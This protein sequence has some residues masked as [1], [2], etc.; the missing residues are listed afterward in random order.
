MTGVSCNSKSTEEGSEIVV[1]PSIVAIKQFSFKS[2]D[3]I[4]DNLDS[5]FF[6]IDLKT[7]VIFN[8]IYLPVGTDV[9]RIVPNITFANNMSKAQFSFLKDN[10]EVVSSDYL[11]NP[12]D[13][14]DFTHPVTLDVTAADGLSSFTYQIRVNI[15]QQD[16][17]SIIWTRM[18]MASLPSRLPD[19]KAQKTIVQN[20]W[21]Y[22]MVE[23]SDGSFTLSKS[24]D[25]NQA[26]WQTV[27]ISLPF[28]PDVETFS[29][30]GDA[31]YILS[32]DGD[33]YSSDDAESWD[34]TGENWV[35]ILGGYQ[36]TV[37]GVKLMDNQLVHAQYPLSDTYLESSVEES[38][39]I[40]LTST[41]GEIETR[42]ASKPMMIMAGGLT[43]NGTLS[44]AIWGFDGENW[45]II[46]QSYLPAL[47]SPMLVRYVAYR[48]TN[49]AFKKR[50]F[51]VWLLFGGYTEDG[52]M[53]REVYMSYDN[54]VN[55]MLAPEPMQ[56]SDKVPY[57]SGAQ[58][59]TEGSPLSADMAEAWTPLPVTK[60]RASYTIEGTEITWI[61]PYIYIFGGYLSSQGN[62]L[63]TNIYRG[64]LERLTMMPV[65]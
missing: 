7:G 50:E 10:K 60:S 37:L 51:D 3:S 24:N 61:C 55:W 4:L 16:P 22:C 27:S 15:F 56:L 41:M 59:L 6:S 25:L 19:P 44:D 11:T 36:N 64:V 2:N 53:N 30:S 23:E 45:A 12:G 1:T 26:N 58:A 20:E 40:N 42:W 28:T 62:V 43:Q 29:A 33:L 34:S 49:A 39:P 54:G 8:A 47:A 63:N 17:D 9:S 32:V 65:I 52:E 57:L 48:A 38:F 5:V 14:I 21:T 13:S 18:Q 31:F 35:N 46:N